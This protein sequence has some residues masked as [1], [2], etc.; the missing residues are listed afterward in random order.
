MITLTEHQNLVEKKSSSTVR[1]VLST[2]TWVS[3]EILDE[4]RAGVSREN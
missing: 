4:D 2:W 1:K 3:L